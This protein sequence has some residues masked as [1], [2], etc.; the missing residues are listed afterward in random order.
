MALQVE[1]ADLRVLVSYSISAFVLGFPVS[2]CFTSSVSV[3]VTA[4]RRG[5]SSWKEV[6]VVS[7]RSAIRIE[8]LIRYKLK[9]HISTKS[10]F[11]TLLKK[12]IA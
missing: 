2:Q 8:L 5:E 10:I 12:V 6:D 11:T 9:N 3:E 4:I 1:K 7:V